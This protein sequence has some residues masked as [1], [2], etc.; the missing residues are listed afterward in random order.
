M[1]YVNLV[2]ACTLICIALCIT[3]NHKMGLTGIIKMGLLGSL[4]LF[5]NLNI[6]I[7]IQ[8]IYLVLYIALSIRLVFRY[9]TKRMLNYIVYLLIVALPVFIIL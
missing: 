7:T 8:L 2:V 4:I 5:H 3:T 1:W 6:N 9:E